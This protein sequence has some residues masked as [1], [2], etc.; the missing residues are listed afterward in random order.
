M[1]M[2][3]RK[4]IHQFAMALTLGAVCALTAQAQEQRMVIGTIQAPTAPETRAAQFFAQDVDKR[5]NGRIRVNVVPASQLGPAGEQIQ[6]VRTGAQDMFLDDISWNAQLVKDY[7]VLAVPF[8]INGQQGFNQVMDSALGDSWRKR[9]RDE[10]GLET[11]SDRFMRSP[12]VVFTTKGVSSLADMA[13]MRFRVPEIDVYF[14]SW[15]AIGVNPTPVP[16]GELYLALRQGVVEGGEG[17]FTTLLPTKFPEVAKFV[18]ETNH[19]YS[20][21]TLMINAK[22]FAALSA[23]DQKALRDA[24]T[25]AAAHYMKLVADQ[26]GEHRDQMK[27]KFGVTFGQPTVQ[28]RDAFR[29]QVENAVPSFESK[30]L[31]PAGVYARVI[32]AQK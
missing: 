8:A 3:R 6:N 2:T 9:L 24:A 29:K 10:F 18:L 17:P 28:Q 7:G 13:N 1:T 14:N 5:T 27:T 16:W 21:N 23:G 30:G 31:W 32:A 15:R 25:A 26:E 12:R 4:S 20:A 22:K 11:L 19:L